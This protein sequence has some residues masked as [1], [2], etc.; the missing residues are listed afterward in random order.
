MLDS[1]KALDYEERLKNLVEKISYLFQNNNDAAIRG[2]IKNQPINLL[3]E[4]LEFLGD[5]NIILRF[6][7]ISYKIKMGELFLSLTQENKLRVLETIKSG[8]LSYLL[9]DLN[10]DDVYE[11]F[12]VSSPSIQKKIMFNS[13]KELKD[14][15]KQLKSFDFAQAGSIMNTTFITFLA[16]MSVG[17]AVNYLKL[18]KD[19]FD[20]EEEIY[21]LNSDEEV[22]GVIKTKDFMFVDSSVSILDLMDKSFLSIHVSEDIDEVIDLFK[23][24]SANS[25][26][27]INAENKLAGIIHYKDVIPEILDSNVEDLYKFYGIKDIRKPYL[28]SGV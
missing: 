1:K 15:I 13:S 17:E 3:V 27:V 19:S 8:V 7:V 20:I 10:S 26:A 4:A 11:I 16:G 18:K 28:S 23:K 5:I 12:S 14:E 9:T 25:V 22:L 21:V 2:L 24:Y 6:L